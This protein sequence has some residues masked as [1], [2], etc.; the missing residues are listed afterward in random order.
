[1][2]RQWPGRTAATMAVLLI[3]LLSLVLSRNGAPIW[4]D[5]WAAHLAAQHHGPILVRAARAVTRLG[6]ALVVYPV[7]ALA[8]GL[9]AARRQRAAV[10]VTP[11]LLLLLAQSLRRAL[12]DAV[13]RPRPPASGHLVASAGW[14]FPSG[15]TALATVGYGLTAQLLLMSFG[16]STSRRAGRLLA[17]VTTV[18]VATVGLSRVE[19]GVHWLSDVIG[20][21]AYG[22]I[23]LCATWALLHAVPQAFSP[24]ASDDRTAD[25]DADGPRRP[26]GPQPPPPAS[27]AP[28]I[29][30]RYQPP[31]RPA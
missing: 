14:S 4:P 19:L 5:R 10:V 2:S 22:M 8:A 25:D 1:M 31:Q 11:V 28:R 24:Q 26:P 21:W 7:L 13:G 15:H 18:L 6:T 27:R 17:G 3:L 12:A 20:G 30:N 23:V 9:A 16:W 29:R